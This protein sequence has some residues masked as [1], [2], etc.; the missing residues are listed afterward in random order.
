MKQL[1]KESQEILT[2]LLSELQQQGQEQSSPT[3]TSPLINHPNNSLNTPLHWAAL[4]THLEC[5]KALVNAGADIG[6]RN[7]AGHDAVFLAERTGWGATE[8]GD[9]EEKEGEEDAE[10][11]EAEESSGKGREVVEW[12]LGCKAGEKLEKGA[13]DGDGEETNAEIDVKEEDEME[14]VAET[15]KGKKS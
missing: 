3:T 14:G 9:G 8:V 15:G 5:V 4:N 12:L 2:Y 13:A 6:A 7:D 11:E 1:T 10:G